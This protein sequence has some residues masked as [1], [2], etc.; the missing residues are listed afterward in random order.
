M[1]W[2]DR[3]IAD[4]DYQAAS[5]EVPTEKESWK[6]R[7][8]SND[9]YNAA[10]GVD[11]DKPSKAESFLRG[12][13]EG[14]TFGFGDELSA[15]AQPGVNKV[16]DALNIGKLFGGGYDVGD[17][18]TSTYKERRDEFRKENMDAAAAN[19]GYNLVGNVL[20]AIPASIAGGGLLAGAG[21]G[22]QA[23]S[24]AEKAA[25]LA[26]QGLMLSTAEGALAGAGNSEELNTT[27]GDTLKGGAIGLGVGAAGLGVAAGANKISKTLSKAD[28]IADTLA[29]Q[30]ARRALGFKKQHFNKLAGGA[31]Q[32]DEIAGVLRKK[33]LFKYG[34]S[35]EAMARSVNEM[36][37]EAYNAI[38]NIYNSTG[39]GDEI[40]GN[41]NDIINRINTNVFPDQKNLASFKP[42][43]RKLD[44]VIADIQAH[45]VNEA[46]DLTHN[47]ILKIKQF[48][49]ELGFDKGANDRGS[50]VYQKAWQEAK[51][52]ID[53]TI[54]KASSKSNLSNLKEANKLYFSAEKGAK[55][56][57]NKINQESSNRA[58]SLMK[59]IG[60]GIGGTVGGVPGAIAGYTA[61][62]L[63][64][65]FGQ[66]TAS[67]VLG[68]TA[69]KLQHPVMKMVTNAPAKFGEKYGRV[70]SQAAAR[71]PSAVASTHYTMMQKDPEYRKQYEKYREQEFKKSE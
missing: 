1:S 12:A 17:T 22:A 9:D 65:R 66:Q 20:G 49:G 16:L 50:K 45:A 13:G 14:A 11:P 71:G 43:K 64:D 3:A 68:S 2:K 41:A 35:E 24:K 62:E 6:S 60:G 33:G 56:L 47:G 36:K 34:I 46:G 58:F 54:E 31:E 38:D 4:K 40:G 55:A 70:L 23:L 5:E 48:L 59:S 44:D 7:A 30:H 29:D 8:L 18:D 67:K 15:A 32:A 25:R 26:K 52:Y 61:M 19:P 63:G 39:L 69:K 51:N 37:E 53:E 21:K 42:Y 10:M 27:L 28:K 57:K